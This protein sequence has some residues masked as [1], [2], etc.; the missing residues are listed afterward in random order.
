MTSLSVKAKDFLGFNKK[1]L[2]PTL[3]FQITYTAYSGWIS[4]G[5][6]TWSVDKIS[7][8]DSF[9]KSLSVCMRGLVLESA[10]PVY[11]PL[12]PGECNVPLEVENT[13]TASAVLKFEAM[14]MEAE[15]ASSESKP[16]G[17][18]GPFT[19]EQNYD[20]VDAV[21]PPSKDPT[22][23]R[24]SPQTGLGP[25]T[26][27]QNYA[28]KITNSKP[29]S[30]HAG[31]GSNQNIELT[32]PEESVQVSFVPKDAVEGPSSGSETKKSASSPWSYLDVSDA[33]SNSLENTEAET[34]RGFSGTSFVAS[35]TSETPARSTAETAINVHVEVREP[36]LQMTKKETGRSMRLPEITEPILRP[37]ST[38]QNAKSDGGAGDPRRDDLQE[39]SSSSALHAPRSFTVQFLPERLAGIL[40]QAERYARQTLLPLISQYTPSFVGSARHESVKYFPPLTD[41]DDDRS[42]DGHVIDG[43]AT[44]NTQRSNE[45]DASVAQRSGDSDANNVDGSKSNNSSRSGKDIDIVEAPEEARAGSD[46]RIE[47][48]TSGERAREIEVGGSA[49]TSVDQQG[50]W[51]PIQ[52]SDLYTKTVSDT[53]MSGRNSS[54]S[55]NYDN[56]DGKWMSEDGGAWKPA[57]EDAEA[58]PDTKID[59]WVPI[60]DKAGTDSALVETTTNDSERNS[61]EPAVTITTESS[62]NVASTST[63]IVEISSTE[64]AAVSSTSQP[65][66]EESAR[67]STAQPAKERKFIPLIDFENGETFLGSNRASEAPEEADGDS[68]SSST[69]KPSHIQRIPGPVESREDSA[70]TKRA[71]IFPYA[72]ERRKDPRTRYI[73]LIPVDDMGKRNPLMERDR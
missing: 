39:S 23:E 40:A 60:V 53:S 24:A 69:Q 70:I 17:G 35:S 45:V 12:Y 49:M 72:Y 58:G 2:F 29:T 57:I 48:L 18:I 61:V 14:K 27:E 38:R 42:I 20:K 71:M 16:S 59:D 31:F 9:G 52:P 32:E 50:D 26:K 10:K 66:V 22:E 55:L 56:L 41:I 73:P 6:V 67:R 4:S 8:L 7:V 25:Y 64:D 47:S 37:R 36:V 54:R 3:N 51:I 5:L 43:A 65:S 13:T 44:G 63:K 34:G 19:R 46:E 28:I 11:L 21:A 30:G 68:A 62:R 1:N 15:E 33:G